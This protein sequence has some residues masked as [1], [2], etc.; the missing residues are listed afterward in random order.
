MEVILKQSLP[1][2]GDADELIK[3]RPGYARNYLLPRG[4]AVLATE[5]MKKMLAEN[6]KQRAHKAQKIKGDAEA[7]AKS[8]ENAIV[9][10][11][12]RVSDK[13]T[14]YGSVTPLQIADELKKLG[15]EIE[16]KQIS[17]DE[18]HIKTPGKYIAHVS[19][20]KDLKVDLNFEVVAE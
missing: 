11:H 12:T 14:I 2:L 18:D 13:G 6:L 5:P 1:N 15:F 4:Y 19:L 20:H 17:V 3:V 9:I 10:I 7:I 16:R 8:L